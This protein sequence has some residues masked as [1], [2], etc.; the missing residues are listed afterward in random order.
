MLLNHPHVRIIK[1]VMKAGR[2]IRISYSMFN[3][4]S[5]GTSEL[6]FQIIAK[7]SACESNCVVKKKKKKK[8]VALKAF[9]R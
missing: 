7:E 6:F 9:I 4:S 1:A 5:N 2:V 3:C 8:R